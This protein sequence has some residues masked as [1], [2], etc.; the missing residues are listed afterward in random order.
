LP[1]RGRGD[2]SSAAAAE[3][4]GEFQSPRGGGALANTTL[5]APVIGTGFPAHIPVAPF[6]GL[7]FRIADDTDGTHPGTSAS[8]AF[9]VNLT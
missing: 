8:W 4:A 3:L 2:R 6:Y 1:F 5:S 7:N 9:F